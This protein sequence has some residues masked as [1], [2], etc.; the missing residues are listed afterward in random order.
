MFLFKLLEPFVVNNHP[1]PLW[2]R[3]SCCVTRTDDVH[4]DVLRGETRR[5]VVRILRTLDLKKGRIFRGSLRILIVSSM[6]LLQ[7][8]SIDSIGELMLENPSNRWIRK[9]KRSSKRT[10]LLRPIKTPSTLRDSLPFSLKRPLLRCDAAGVVPMEPGRAQ[11]SLCSCVPR[12]GEGCCVLS[13]RN[14]NP[15][16][17]VDQK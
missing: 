16:T 12:L 4:V 9:T 10:N 6:H 2:V 17:W 7:V 13:T 15:A 14:R 11:G 8:F 1:T 3:C 5:D